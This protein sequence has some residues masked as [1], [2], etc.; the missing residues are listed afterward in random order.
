[1]RCCYFYPMEQRQV[2]VSGMGMKS[3]N[4]PSLEPKLCRIAWDFEGQRKSS[5]V[6]IQY[7]I[8]TSFLTR[9]SKTT[10]KRYDGIRFGPHLLTPDTAIRRYAFGAWVAHKLPYLLLARRFYSSL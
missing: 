4:K 8:N 5:F 3:C 1:M 9:F 7:E 6:P 10:A 2:N